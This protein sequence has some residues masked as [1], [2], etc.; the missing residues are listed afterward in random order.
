MPVLNQRPTLGIH[1]PTTARMPWAQYGVSQ[2]MPQDTTGGMAFP[3]LPAFGSMFGGGGGG[4]TVPWNP[5]GG[6][7]LIDGLGPFG[8]MSTGMPFTA[9]EWNYLGGA[10]TGTPLTG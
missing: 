7:R 5:V 3:N 8:F 2:A 1:A 4:D 6:D 9:G 10:R